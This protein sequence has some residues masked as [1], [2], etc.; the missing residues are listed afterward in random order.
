VSTLQASVA[1]AAIGYRQATLAEH[2][3]H[4]GLELWMAAYGY[5]IVSLPASAFA[6]RQNE[7]D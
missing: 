5:R 3:R 1:A 7:D 2:P 6:W 4:P